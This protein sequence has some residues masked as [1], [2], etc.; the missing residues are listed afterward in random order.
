MNTMMLKQHLTGQLGMGCIEPFKCHV[1]PWQDQSINCRGLFGLAD[2]KY[3]FRYASP[4]FFY[5]I[6]FVFLLMVVEKGPGQ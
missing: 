1:S 2:C 6:F 3:L 4:Y 5:F